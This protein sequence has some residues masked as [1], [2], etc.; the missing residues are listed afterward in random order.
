MSGQSRFER[1]ENEIV[2]AL[3]RSPGAEPSADLDARILARA[4]A[5]VAKTAPRRS[6][7]RWMSLAAG[8]VVLVG[9]GLALRIWQQVEHA[10]N[11]L[12]APPAL[13]T[14]AASRPIDAIGQ[15]SAVDDR[16]NTVA[17]NPKAVVSS[18][19]PARQEASAS[20]ENI[21]ETAA[22]PAARR[23][24]SLAQP[25]PAVKML[26]SAPI[27]TDRIR[28]DQ[29]SAVMPVA[30]P[31]MEPSASAAASISASDLTGEAQAYPG[32]DNS[33][34]QKSAEAASLRAKKEGAAAPAAVAEG[35]SRSATRQMPA[36]LTGGSTA[37]G[38][39]MGALADAPD[40]LGKLSDKGDNYEQALT[41]IRAAL[42]RGDM[43]E[44]RRLVQLLRQNYPER[45]LPKDLVFADDIQH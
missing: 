4:H 11:P 30:P 9:S 23:E 42:K 35:P 21:A 2:D 15:N 41:T 36:A 34:R 5:A 6:Q 37:S 26:P 20:L 25:F 28:S 43:V 17:F 10:P 19:A 8:V 38:M 44:A 39:T 27:E 31:P 32:F 13:T 29:V 40:E 33:E 45:Q 14:P 22:T 3:R 12:D 18:P 24:Q 1:L 16:A 7:P